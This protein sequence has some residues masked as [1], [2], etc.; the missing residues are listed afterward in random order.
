[1]TDKVFTVE[2]ANKMLPLVRR[3]VEDAVRD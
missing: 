2:Q 1:M 3:I